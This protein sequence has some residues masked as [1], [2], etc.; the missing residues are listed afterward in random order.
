MG[1]EAGAG[2]RG[3]QPELLTTGR[4]NSGEAE[5]G[6]SQQTERRFRRARAWEEGFRGGS[7]PRVTCGSWE[8]RHSHQMGK[9]DGWRCH[10][11]ERLW[12]RAAFGSGEAGPRGVLGLA[13]SGG[14]TALLG[15]Q[16]AHGDAPRWPHLLREESEARELGPSL[17]KAVPSRTQSS[18]GGECGHGGSRASTGTLRGL[19]GQGKSSSRSTGRMGRGAAPSPWWPHGGGQGF[20]FHRT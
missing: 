4:P 15:I 7:D 20:L 17:K 8:P 18:P 11:Q 14:F 6:S 1:V 5:D 2:T 19:P 12:D 3:T 13:A 16:G 9:R 10:V